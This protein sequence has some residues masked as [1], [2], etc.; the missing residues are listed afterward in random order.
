MTEA[1]KAIEL[2]NK[3]RII[4]GKALAQNIRRGLAEE[5]AA[6]TRRQGSKPGLATVLVG[7]DPASAVYVRNKIKAC[8]EIGMETFDHHL[9]AASSEKELLTLVGG[10]SANPAVHGILIQQPLPPQIS[11]RKVLEA[12]PD[13][14][15]VDGFGVVNSG[16]FFLARALADLEFCFIPCT[17]YGV[18]KMIQSVGISL[19][20]RL[21]CVLGRSSIVGKPLAHLLMLHNATVM[22]CHSKTLRLAQ[23]VSQADIVIAAIGKPKFLTKDMVRPGACVIDVGINRLSSGQLVGDCDF[24]SVCEAA[25]FITPGPGGVGPMTIAMLL[26]NT[27]KSWKRPMPFPRPLP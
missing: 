5:I 14:K 21:V 2:K 18:L 9:P 20:G 22:I 24:E 11:A 4:D 1:K 7:A 27:V 17:P 8:R 23:M 19:Q 15:D 16:R 25:A 26:S 10:L 6:L 3:A 13:A 12:L